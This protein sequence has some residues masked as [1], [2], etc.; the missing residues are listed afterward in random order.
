LAWLFRDYPNRYLAWMMRPLAWLMLKGL[1]MGLSV[2][3]YLKR[4]RRKYS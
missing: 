2:R 3:G 1:L 4:L